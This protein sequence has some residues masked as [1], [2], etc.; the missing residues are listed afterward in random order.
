MET[1]NIAQGSNPEQGQHLESSRVVDGANEDL[2]TPQITG[3]ENDGVDR[4]TSHSAHSSD[5]GE[6]SDA[7][8]LTEDECSSIML[9]TPSGV[10]LAQTAS[11]N[12]GGGN[13]GASNEEGEDERVEGSGGD[14][15]PKEVYITSL[16][17]LLFR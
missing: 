6:S 17:T 10:P 8:P 14:E 11:R 5:Q 3:Q 12:E 13:P 2:A 4:N 15:R 16:G 9:G 1:S 7:V